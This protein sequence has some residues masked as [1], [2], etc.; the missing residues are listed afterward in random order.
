MTMDFMNVV[1]GM[2]CNPESSERYNAVNSLLRNAGNIPSSG[3]RQTFCS[4]VTLEIKNISKQELAPYTAVNLLEPVLKTNSPH[5]FAFK[6]SAASDPQTPWG[7]TTALI[8]PGCWG[9][10][11]VSGITPARF[12]G[13]EDGQTYRLREAVPGECATVCKDGVIPSGSGNAQIIAA[14]YR[15]EKNGIWLP[16]IISIGS[17][18]APAAHNFN[19]FCTSVSPLKFKITEGRI[20]FAPAG[21]SGVM[22]EAEIDGVSGAEYLCLTVEY[23][24]TE[25]TGSPEY[26]YKYEFLSS[27]TSITGTREKAFVFLLAT[28]R[29]NGKVTV[30]PGIQE[31]IYMRGWML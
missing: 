6:A 28:C 30:N 11:V 12:A 16:G 18:F 31:Q 2:T 24:R 4:G 23:T 8:A 14:P 13:Y 26:T 7:I 5:I 29:N 25:T 17:W 3:P 22:P 19:V 21:S 15:V 9:E 10:A 27:Y 1:P 20:P